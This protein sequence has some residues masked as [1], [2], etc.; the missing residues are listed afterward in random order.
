MPTVNVMKLRLLVAFGALI[1]ISAGGSSTLSIVRN[2][3][4]ASTASRLAAQA[5]VGTSFAEEAPST[6]E[7]R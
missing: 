3:L 4:A 1:L 5:A 2:Q 6:E 7:T